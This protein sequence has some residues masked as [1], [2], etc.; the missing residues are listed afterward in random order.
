V[1]IG[2]R[3]Y[4]DFVEIRLSLGHGYHREVLLPFWYC[5]NGSSIFVLKVLQICTKL[6]VFKFQK[7]AIIMATVL[8][9]C[10]NL[11]VN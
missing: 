4:V 9:F 2:F 3:K 5:E 11:R 10:L 6:H 8:A 7:I 1:S